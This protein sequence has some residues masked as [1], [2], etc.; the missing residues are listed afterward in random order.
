[1]LVWRK[2]VKLKGVIVKQA[3]LYKGLFLFGFIPLYI[4]IKKGLVGQKND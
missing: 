4:S 1:M 2:W 3:V